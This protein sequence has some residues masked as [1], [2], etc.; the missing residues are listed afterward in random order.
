MQICKFSQLRLGVFRKKSRLFSYSFNRY[1]DKTKDRSS[2][3]WLFSGDKYKNKIKTQSELTKL[4]LKN[5][6][7]SENRKFTLSENLIHNPP[8]TKRKRE[9][10]IETKSIGKDSKSN[11]KFIL[12]FFSNTDTNE[13]KIVSLEKLVRKQPDVKPKNNSQ[14]TKS[15]IFHSP[16]EIS[17]KKPSKPSFN[18]DKAKLVV[19]EKAFLEKASYKIRNDLL[20]EKGNELLKTFSSL[21]GQSTDPIHMTILHDN[22]STRLSN[23][24]YEK[25]FQNNN[26]KNLK[27]IWIEY[28][29]G[30]G[31]VTRKLIEKFNENATTRQKFLMLEPLGKFSKYLKEIVTLNEAKHDV[32]VMKVN[33]YE[34]EFLFKTSKFKYTFINDITTNQPNPASSSTPK[35]QVKETDVNEKVCMNIFGTVPW[36]RKGF[37]STL[38]SDYASN[39]G[40][41]SLGKTKMRN[42]FFH[43]I[44]E[45]KN[46]NGEQVTR[47]I[48]FPEFYLYVPEI[49][50]AKLRAGYSKEYFRFNSPLSIFSYA[51]SK[52]EVLDE[53]KCDYFFPYPIMSQKLSRLNGLDFKKMFLISIKFHE[54]KIKLD[55]EDD[56]DLFVQQK[57][58]SGL[59]R[60]KHLFFLFINH[61]FSRPS[62]PL[63]NSLKNVCKDVDF[64][65][66]ENSIASYLPVR[67][68]QIHK[69]ATLYN[70]LLD[71]KSISNLDL[72]STK[73]VQNEVNEDS[74]NISFDQSN[75]IKEKLTKNEL[76]FRNKTDL[77]T[78]KSLNK[79]FSGQF[80]IPFSDNTELCDSTPIIKEPKTISKNEQINNKDIIRFDKKK[81]ESNHDHNIFTQLTVNN[82]C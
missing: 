48:L 53:E 69:F 44:Q 20:D 27:N 8:V 31:L 25:I 15:D 24:F 33:P 18:S 39:R 34:R 74:L 2:D 11:S 64:V 72:L 75:R 79:N 60:N 46:A 28:N 1:S 77:A 80:L 68:V 17:T 38:F 43:E 3:N 82:F 26:D 70:Y 5:K 29:P 66:K 4:I 36:N 73:Y 49:T 16:P 71:N 40:L 47:S 50:V 19:K 61:L 32:T 13:S 37:V 41:F 65:C 30:F 12:D 78:L 58:F 52:T 56:D 9:E 6:T 62:E 42:Y 54:D 67:N 23:L 10:I 51:F 76:E 45:N 63:R 14:Q 55:K 59:I 7:F 81:S 35:C 57:T 21:S 22:F